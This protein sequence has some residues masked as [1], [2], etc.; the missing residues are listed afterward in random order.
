MTWL[1]EDPLPIMVMGVILGVIV[2]VGFIKT[3]QRWLIAALAGVVLLAIAVLAIEQMVVTDREEVELVL[4]EIAAAVERND[5]DA[6]LL[7]I[8]PDAPGVHRANTELRRITFREVDIKPN[9]EIEVFPDRTPPEA[10][11]RFNVVVIADVGIGGG[12]D[13]YPRYV[14][15]TF[16][17]EGERW[18]VRDY[19]HYEPTRG[20]RSEP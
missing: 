8:S 7:H 11:T 17:K 1:I 2:A 12:A 18:V 19:D 3:G 16:V 5:I 6:A 15:A 20:M 10:Q 9:L 4:F 13:R 14:E